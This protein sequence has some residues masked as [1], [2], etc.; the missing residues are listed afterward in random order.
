MGFPRDHSGRCLRLRLPPTPC[1]E[2][3]RAEPKAS[4]GMGLARCGG[5]VLADRGAWEFRHEARPHGRAARGFAARP[6]REAC[7]AAD[8]RPGRNRGMH[9]LASSVAPGQGP[10]LAAG[11]RRR[12]EAPQSLTIFTTIVST[13]LE[14]FS[15]VP[16]D[17]DFFSR[18]RRQVYYGKFPLRW[19]PRFDAH[20]P[21]AL[22]R[23]ARQEGAQ[24]RR[25]PDAHPTG[26]AVAGG[27]DQCAGVQPDHPL[28]AGIRPARP[29]HLRDPTRASA[30]TAAG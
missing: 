7:L 26:A 4:A 11:A 21:R 20:A 16:A 28:G 2:R 10:S 13:Q 24:P 19:R 22:A 30:S 25:P 6:R 27:D 15:P 5:C 14:H 29:A 3:E 8:F 9:V 17:T 1:W 12:R 18:A 23:Q